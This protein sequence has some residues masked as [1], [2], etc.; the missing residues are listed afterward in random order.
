MSSIRSAPLANLWRMATLSQPQRDDAHTLAE[1]G[2]GTFP[3]ESTLAFDWLMAGLGALFIGGLYIDGWAHNHLGRIETFFTPWHA[4]FYGSFALLALVLG[5]YVFTGL[6]TSGS[7]NRAIPRGYEWSVIGVAIFLLAGAGD[8]V[9]HIRFGIE[10]DTEALLSPTHL[11][12]AAGMA[13]IF[14]GPLRA[15]I[16]R[17][18]DARGAA[19]WPAVVSLTLLM[20]G[21]TFLVQF[22]PALADWGVGVRPPAA[23]LMEQRLDRA[24][25]SELWI[26]AVMVASVLFL[27][28][29]WGPRL[30]VGSMTC[31]IGVNAA[32][33]STQAGKEY[34][35]AML[36]AAI[37]AAVICDA[38]LVWLRPSAERIVQFRWFAFLVPFVYWTAH[39]L[40]NLARGEHVWWA[41]H[42]WAGLPVICGLMGLMLSYL[43]V[44]GP[45]TPRAGAA[46]T[47][48]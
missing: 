38:L 12:L 5:S 32:I 24:L 42:V 28:R 6:R 26:N 21:L 39:Y 43:A 17:G 2:A 27:V 3:R 20:S 48:A 14:T 36:P 15:A 8:M 44:T 31:L 9:W 45:A 19:L 22:A 34:Y 37:I 18:D 30:P 16:A 46:D 4:M 29:Q 35:F 1:T 25:V 23:D 41:V 47:P 7:W 40:D 33:M 11:G 10:H 13:L